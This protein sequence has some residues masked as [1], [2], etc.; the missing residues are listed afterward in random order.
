MVTKSWMYLY[1]DS[2]VISHSLLSFF[3]FLT[4][5]QPFREPISAESWDWLYFYTRAHTW[6]SVLADLD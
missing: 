2:H 4:G 3:F 1:G 6:L 5:I